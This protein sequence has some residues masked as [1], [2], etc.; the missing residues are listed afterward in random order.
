MADFEDDNNPFGDH[1][2]G[3]T[4]PVTPPREVDNEVPPM[5]P[6]KTPTSVAQ[7]PPQSYK[8]YPGLGPK[9]GFC[10]VRDE[11]LHSDDAEIQASLHGSFGQPRIP[12]AVHRLS[13]LSR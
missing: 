11:Y 2:E 8:G 3:Q 5:T 7:V 12:H 9:T 10:C 1:D 13:T 6:A 4:V